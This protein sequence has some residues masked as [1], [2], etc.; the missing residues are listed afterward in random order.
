MTHF[1]ILVAANDHANEINRIF[2]QKIVACQ[3]SMSL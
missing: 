1:F 3:G 2:D